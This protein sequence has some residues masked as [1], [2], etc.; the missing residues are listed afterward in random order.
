[1]KLIVKIVQVNL[2]FMFTFVCVNLSPMIVSLSRRCS[3]YCLAKLIL[4]PKDQTYVF[5]LVK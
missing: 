2:F 4:S 5:S 3:K 1:M